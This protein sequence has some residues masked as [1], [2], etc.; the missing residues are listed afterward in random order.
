M[1]DISGGTIFTGELMSGGDNF[2]GG[3]Y[4]PCLVSAFQ[5]I[6]MPRK[7][8]NGVCH[9][10]FRDS[11]RAR[12]SNAYATFNMLMEVFLHVLYIEYGTLTNHIL[13]V[14]HTN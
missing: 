2:D 11:E 12:L 1:E 8:L 4:T 14:R 13:F 3:Q 5:D 6:Q 10:P 7:Y 9:S